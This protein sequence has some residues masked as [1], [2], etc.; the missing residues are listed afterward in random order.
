MNNAKKKS[1]KT[2]IYRARGY[3]KIAEFAPCVPVE[4]F[5]VFWQACRL[6]WD[7]VRYV[8]GAENTVVEVKE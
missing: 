7:N 1:G 3:K 2:A 5:E 4:L 6:R 8:K